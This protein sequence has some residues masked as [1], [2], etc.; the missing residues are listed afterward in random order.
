MKQANEIKCIFMRL[1]KFIDKQPPEAESSFED[2]SA[3]G[4][5]F[6]V[7]PFCTFFRSSF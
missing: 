1:K 6:L 5:F 2:M 7:Y 3:S 4:V